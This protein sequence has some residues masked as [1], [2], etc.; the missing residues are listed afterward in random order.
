[1]AGDDNENNGASGGDPMSRKDVLRMGLSKFKE[2][3]AFAAGWTI[4]SYASR[5]IPR[6]QRPPGAL[7]EIDFLLA[8]TRCDECRKVCP[9]GA[10]MKLDDQA[11]MAAGTPFL[12]VNRYRACV[13]CEDAPCMAA[14]PTGALQEIPM[15][16]AVMG[17]A[18]IDRDTCRAWIGATCDRCIQACPYPD[19]AILADEDGRVYVDPR[20]CI[21]C[22][23][24]VKACPT[25]PR[26]VKVDPPPRF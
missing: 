7:A 8:C 24:C 18:T 3:G 25:R 22:G 2:A 17:T 1:M 26:S 4:E 13:V 14:C 23:R 21:G 19:D 15:S 12:E 5:F 6:V 11:G 9:V 16:E 20:S 10:I